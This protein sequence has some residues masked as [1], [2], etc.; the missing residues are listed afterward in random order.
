GHHF[1]LFQTPRLG[2]LH[3]TLTRGQ[4]VLGDINQTHVSAILMGDSFAGHLTRG[5]DNLLKAHKLKAISIWESGCLMGPHLVTLKNGTADPACLKATEAALQLIRDYDAPI[6]IAESWSGGYSKLLGRRDEGAIQFSSQEKYEEFLYQNI[7]EIRSYAGNHRHI[8]V[9]G[10]PPGD[11]SYN[12]V[13]LK[14]CLERPNYIPSK[15]MSHLIFPT[16]K[17]IGYEENREL[18]KLLKN[19]AGILFLDPY[20][21]FCHDSLCA[22]MPDN[23]I[24]YSD[25]AHLSILGS[26]NQIN[27][28]S[29]DILT[30]LAP[31]TRAQNSQPNIASH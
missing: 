1:E 26:I 19:T 3:M 20:K 12:G 11:G 22:A 30:V 13:N 25:A 8:I 16:N 6:L 9:F 17:G 15:C 4:S 31:A 18:A 7:Q 21:Y 14:S 28:F 10:S 29:S 2:G 24:A 23:R 27:F 5:L